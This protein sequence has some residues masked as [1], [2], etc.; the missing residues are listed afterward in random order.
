MENRSTPEETLQNLVPEKELME[1]LGVSR[2]SLDRLRHEKQLP[3]IRAN[4]KS[5][6]YP[7]SSLM[8]WVRDQE[9]VLDR[10]A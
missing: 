5:R 6:L 3:F 10:D 8:N 2:G 9:I 4:R 1:I 7:E